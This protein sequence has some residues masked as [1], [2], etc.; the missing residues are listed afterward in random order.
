MTFIG[1][2][3]TRELLTLHHLV[4]EMQQSDEVRLELIYPARERRNNSNRITI[5]GGS[6]NP[7]HKGHRTLL[8]RTIESIDGAEAIA[9]IT[10]SHSLGKQYTGA[11]YAQRLYMLQ[12]EQ[13]RLPFM[14]VGVIN[15]GYYRNWFHRLNE[16]HPDEK[17]KYF[18]VMGVDLFPRVIHGNTEQDYQ[19]IF[20]IDW[21]V[22]ERNRKNWQDY[23]IPECITPYL[24]KISQVTMS[25]DTQDISSSALKNLINQRDETVL[26]FI[27][28]D[29]L[30]FV[31]RYNIQY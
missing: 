22:A 4:Q 17:N 10:L 3:E 5:C 25:D 7:F 29:V 20:G 24:H 13:E 14:S 21:I 28:R 1:Q 16:F 23:A 27:T 19:K 2:A 15:D 31:K 12:M 9:Y 11:D 8:T 18:C 30:D 6:F 26:E